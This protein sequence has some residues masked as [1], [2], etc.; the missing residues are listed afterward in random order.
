MVEF[1]PQSTQHLVDRNEN[2]DSR[3]DRLMMR[4]KAIEAEY[5]VIGNKKNTVVNMMYKK[6]ALYFVPL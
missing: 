3:N 5:Y 1:H 4:L 2:M 6:T